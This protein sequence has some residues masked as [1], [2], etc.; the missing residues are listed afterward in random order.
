MQ[1]EL[2][3]NSINRRNL[4][5]KA[6]IKTTNLA[7]AMVLTFIMTNLPYIVDEF[8]RQRFVSKETCHAG[9]CLF[10]KVQ[11]IINLKKI[12]SELFTRQSL[13]CP[14]CATQPSIRT[15][16]FSSTPRHPWPGN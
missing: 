6:R 10:L 11:F 5:S 12:L 13:A 4:L 8:L 14:L 3:H 7:M 16:S 1:E 15:F 2:P 9:I